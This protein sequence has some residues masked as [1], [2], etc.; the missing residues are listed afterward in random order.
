MGMEFVPMWKPRLCPFRICS[1]ELMEISHC[2]MCTGSVGNWLV[3]KKQFPRL[4]D[5]PQCFTDTSHTS[6]FHSHP[7][8]V[9]WSFCSTSSFN[10]SHNIL[11]LMAQ[12]QGRFWGSVSC[13]RL[14]WHIGCSS[15]NRTTDLMISGWLTHSCLVWCVECVKPQR[16]HQVA[17][18]GECTTSTTVQTVGCIHQDDLWFFFFFTNEDSFREYGIQPFSSMNLCMSI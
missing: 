7:H 1:E 5:Q 4:H 15:W 6:P 10:Y 14:P 17:S 2:Y 18:C 13:P 16:F 8:T 3:L 9:L 11:T 12:N